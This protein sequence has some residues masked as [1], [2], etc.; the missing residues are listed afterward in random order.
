MRGKR[1]EEQEEKSSFIVSYCTSLV[2]LY[3]VERQDDVWIGMG[4][5]ESVL[6]PAGALS[7]HLSGAIKEIHENIQSG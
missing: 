7:L 2:A 3:S 4:L 1:Q 6:G 5:E